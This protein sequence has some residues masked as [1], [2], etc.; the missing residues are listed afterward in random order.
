ME[1]M[2]GAEGGE[3]VEEQGG[4]DPLKKLEAALADVADQAPDEAK[5]AFAAA[6]DAFRQGL[7]LAA[8]GGGGAPANQAVTMEQGGSKGAIPM[9]MGRPA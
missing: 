8:G 5:E 9:S 6:L 2:P 1:K 7:E 3:E 4:S